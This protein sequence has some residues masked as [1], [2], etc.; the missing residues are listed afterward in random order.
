MPDLNS[1]T[2][3]PPSTLILWEAKKERL[4][5]D[6]ALIELQEAQS[7]LQFVL[8][9]N[10]GDTDTVKLAREAVAEAEKK[11]AQEL[12]E[13]DEADDIAAKELAEA[14]QADQ[15]LEYWK[16]KEQS[17]FDLYCGRI[18]EEEY[19]KEYDQWRR[20]IFDLVMSKKFEF[21]IAVV[22]VLN[23]LTMASE[24]HSMSSSFLKFIEISN[25][26]FTFVFFVESM[27]KYI[28]FGI[29]RFHF[30]AFAGWNNFDLFVVIVSVAGIY[31]DH[32][33]TTLPVSPAVLRILRIL[34][35]ARILKLLKSAKDLMVTHPT[36]ANCDDR[37]VLRSFRQ[38]LLVTV[39]NSLR[40]VGNLALLLFLLYF[41][42]A[43]LGM[44]LYGRCVYGPY[45][46]LHHARSRLHSQ[47][48][49]QYETDAA[50]C[51]KAR[52]LVC[53]RSSMSKI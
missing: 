18:E 6:A 51:I 25:Y 49:A 21:V 16:D 31:F 13:A 50:L 30:G 48:G 44:E 10:G 26:L 19:F 34:R 20:D 24:H 36:R 23:I 14:E 40:Q 11:Y 47:C 39:T 35:V 3:K 28:A 15:D 17:Y 9:T 46:C 7:R 45:G 27:L 5:A 42:Y 12:A 38:V 37:R 8:T 4:E 1:E 32:S 2:L 22:I 53:P 43:A 29:W 41:I 33:G 52:H